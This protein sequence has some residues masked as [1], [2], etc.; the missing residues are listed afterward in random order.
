MKSKINFKLQIF[1]SNFNKTKHRNSSPQTKTAIDQRSAICNHSNVIEP[2]WRSAQCCQH[3]SKRSFQGR[4]STARVEGCRYASICLSV[5][6]R[7]CPSTMMM[8]MMADRVAANGAR[9]DLTFL[10]FISSLLNENFE[11]N[12]INVD[13]RIRLFWY[14]RF[15]KRLTFFT[16]GGSWY[17]QQYNITFFR[18]LTYDFLNDP[19]EDMNTYN[20]YSYWWQRFRSERQYSLGLCCD[21]ISHVAVSKFETCGRWW[22]LDVLCGQICKVKALFSVLLWVMFD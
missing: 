3:I 18:V 21:Q 10:F 13:W 8:M 2:T 4:R 17:G 11:L 14:H 5:R 19:Y 16:I 15:L 12:R 7:V 20:M 9:E 6:L 1:K 22:I